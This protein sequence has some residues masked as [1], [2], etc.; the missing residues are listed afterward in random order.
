MQA[1][2]GV[3]ERIGSGGRDDETFVAKRTGG[4]KEER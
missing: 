1:L 2:L 4:R 3:V